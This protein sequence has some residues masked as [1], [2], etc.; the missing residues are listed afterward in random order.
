MSVDL[1]GRP[2]GAGYVSVVILALIL[3]V[4]GLPILGGG[5]YL[6]VLGGSWYYA[7]AGL[8]LVLTAVFLIRRSMTAV[9]IYL[10]T[11]AGTVIWAFWEVG[12]DWWAQV[13]RL[14]APS[15]VL[16]LVLL[17]IPLLRR[18]AILREIYA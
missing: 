7:P 14:V 2:R 10:V 12:T 1:H 18:W 9:W 16:I 15:V 4:F 6:I 8:G 3:L 5:L 11:Y 17:T 13:P